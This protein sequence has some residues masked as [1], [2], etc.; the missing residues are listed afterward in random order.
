MDAQH[1]VNLAKIM[2]GCGLRVSEALKLTKE[3]IEENIKNKSPHYRFLLNDEKI[4]WNDKVKGPIEFQACNLSD[5]ILI[6][7][8]GTMTYMLC[9]VIDDIDYKITDIIR[10]FL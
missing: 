6:R 1:W 8:D 9:S 2:Y 7:Q 10:G 4:S 3:Q 5:P